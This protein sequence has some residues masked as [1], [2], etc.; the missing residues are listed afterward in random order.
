MTLSIAEPDG[1]TWNDWCASFI[2]NN[3]TI[4][5][6]PYPP[7]ESQWQDWA[8]IVRLLPDLQNLNLPDPEGFDRWRD[9]VYRLSGVVA[10]GL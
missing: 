6:I 8:Q 5:D 9:W 1:A 2:L 3:P 4:F 10:A 7:P